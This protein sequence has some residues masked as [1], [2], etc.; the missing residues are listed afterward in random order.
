MVELVDA[1]SR[2]RTPFPVHT[3]YHGVE[4]V[5]DPALY[6][7]AAVEKLSIIA[8]TIINEIAFFIVFISLFSFVLQLQIS[9]LVP[10]W[11]IAIF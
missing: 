11:I 7:K 4:D 3:P 6:A 10:C 5:A 8:R 1:L 2:I 9:K